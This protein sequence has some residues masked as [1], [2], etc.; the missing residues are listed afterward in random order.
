MAFFER[1]LRIWESRRL[2]PAIILRRRPENNSPPRS[3]TA[4]LAGGLLPPWRA[5]RA[6]RLPQSPIFS[7]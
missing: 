7:A 3:I 5:L 1:L 2:R 6:N 4:A